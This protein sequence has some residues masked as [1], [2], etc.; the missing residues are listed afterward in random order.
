MQKLIAIPR[1]RPVMAATV[2]AK[3]SG[4]K[5]ANYV[6]SNDILVKDDLLQS[7]GLA[8]LGLSEDRIS[9]SA[10]LEP[11]DGFQRLENLGA[12]VIESQ[13]EASTE[14]AR[15]ALEG[16]FIV[17]PDASLYLPG[18]KL[19]KRSVRLP[20]SSSHWGEES[21]VAKAHAEGV[22]GEGVLVGV[23]DTG[24]D[25]DHLEF[26][27]RKI[28]YR[29]VP[30]SRNR[31]EI[32]AVRG[33]DVDGHGTH[34]SGIIAGERVGVAP[35]ADLLVASVIESESM[36]TSMERI[37]LGLD[38]MLSHFQ[39][40][41]HA[42]KPT[43]IN[44]SLGF[45][46]EW[47]SG[48]EEMAIL[49]GLQ[50]LLAILVEIDVLPIIAIGNDGPGVMRAPGFFPQVLSV[51]AVDSQLQ[52]AW[53]S[54]GGTH[55]GATEPDVAGFGVDVWSSLERRADNHSLYAQM[56]GTSMATPYVTGI[57][58]LHA[59]RDG[60][61]GAALHSQLKATALPIAAPPDRVGSG[62]ARYS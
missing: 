13:S 44:M 57:A 51:G 21:G 54:G 38:W 23:L 58:A 31:Q 3:S 61:Q 1:K 41:E 20:A 6:R 22:R 55:N 45:R 32:R 34:V 62:L 28:D 12:Y 5:R 30:L 14:Q 53:F 49:D 60:L 8:R 7:V 43:I 4:D 48:P 29:Y 52:P 39:R 24:C 18:A 37:F 50:E 2:S 47:V 46:Q 35:E 19:G 11:K 25:A 56:S 36:K 15:E 16:D 40:D 59:S 10:G 17:M 26:R 42:G 27:N 33:F 9:T